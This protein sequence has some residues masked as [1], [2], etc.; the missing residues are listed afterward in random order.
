M[1]S[2]LLVSTLNNHLNKIYDQVT[3][4]VPFLDY[5]RKRKMSRKWRGNAVK[6]PIK[7]ASTGTGTW[8]GEYATIPISIPDTFGTATYDVKRLITDVIVDKVTVAINKQSNKLAIMDL[9]EIKKREI[10][11]EMSSTLESALI[12][13]AVMGADEPASLRVAAG[14]SSVIGGIDQSANAFWQ[15]QTNND[16]TVLDLEDLDLAVASIRE[17]RGKFT[18]CVCSPKVMAHFA[19]SAQSLGRFILSKD[20]VDI[21]GMI[22]HSYIPYAGGVILGSPAV[23]D[24]DVFFAL[25]NGIELLEPADEKNKLFFDL[26]TSHNIT[27]DVIQGYW[28]GNLIYKSMRTNYFRSGFTLS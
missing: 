8:V 13:D 28:F 5:M 12:Y 10:I 7:K 3:D 16:A 26:A 2:D 17:K 25:G 14:N 6:V 22:G 23:T 1:S 20:A 18:M 9:M 19:K 11:D 27:Y 4:A 15:W 24:D 21:G